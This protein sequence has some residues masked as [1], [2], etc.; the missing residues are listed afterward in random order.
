MRK[1][2]AGCYT[3]YAYEGD[4]VG[5]SCL[6]GEKQL[7]IPTKYGTMLYATKP[8]CKVK[9]RKDYIKRAENFIER[10]TIK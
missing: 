6:V 2:Y 3:C 7:H 10:M 5:A 8:H 4:G 1:K 9:N